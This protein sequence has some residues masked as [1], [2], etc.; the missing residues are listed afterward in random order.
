MKKGFS[1]AGLILG[2]VAVLAGAAAIVF[3][4]IS[5]GQPKKIEF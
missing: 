5:L 2:I 3:S 1:V 4:G